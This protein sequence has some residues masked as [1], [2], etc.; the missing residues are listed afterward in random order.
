MVDTAFFAPAQWAIGNGVSSSEQKHLTERCTLTDDRRRMRLSYTIEDSVYLTEPVTLS[1]TF[2][3]DPGHPWQ[4]EYACDPVASSRHLI[5]LENARGS[6]RLVSV[7]VCAATILRAP[8]FL[9]AVR[10]ASR[11]PALRAVLL[12]SARAFGI[13]VPACEIR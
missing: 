5:R 7:S 8:R 6:G 3:I 10:F 11:F 4:K 9:P 12:P 2:A 1:Q 13:P